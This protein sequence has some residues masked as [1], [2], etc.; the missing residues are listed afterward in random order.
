M[1]ESDTLTNQAEIA[2]SGSIRAGLWREVCTGP[3]RI[4][5]A[6]GCRSRSSDRDR[7]ILR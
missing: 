1:I 2:K 7:L 6:F 4:G 5:D 3:K